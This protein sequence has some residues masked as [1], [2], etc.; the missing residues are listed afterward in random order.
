MA[1][2]PDRPTRPRSEL[3]LFTRKVLIVVGAIAA[4]RAVVV[5]AR[6]P[7]ARLHRR[8]ARRRDRAGGAA[9]AHAAGAISFHRKLSRG[10][11]VMIVYLPFLVDGA[12]PRRW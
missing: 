8:G 3:E 11:A 10:T 9:R 4:L 1:H 5:R 2:Y 12:R 6:R 7:A